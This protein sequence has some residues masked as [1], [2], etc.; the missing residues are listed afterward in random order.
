MRKRDMNGAEKGSERRSKAIAVVPRHVILLRSA[1]SEP[2]ANPSNKIFWT[3][4]AIAI[5]CGFWGS[6]DVFPC[7]CAVHAC[8]V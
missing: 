7:L 4:L 2:S 1:R 3:D 6:Y 5:L 8:G